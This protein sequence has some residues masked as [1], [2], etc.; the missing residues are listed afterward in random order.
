MKD[1][2]QEKKIPPP[3]KKKRGKD[4]EQNQLGADSADFLCNELVNVVYAVNVQFNYEF[5][6]TFPSR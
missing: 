5:T 3:P 1:F 6:S 2:P 4:L